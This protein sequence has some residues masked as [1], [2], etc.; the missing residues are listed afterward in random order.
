MGSTTR[1]RSIYG[2]EYTP[3]G[4]RL[5]AWWKKNGERRLQK[6]GS[7]SAQIRLY[8]NW[9][10]ASSFYRRDARFLKT[11]RAMHVCV[12][13]RQAAHCPGSLAAAPR[14]CDDQIEIDIAKEAY[15]QANAPAK[16]KRQSPL[17][18]RPAQ[19]ASQGEPRL[20]ASI[21]RDRASQGLPGRCALSFF[22][23]L[24]FS[25]FISSK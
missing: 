19:R 8:L 16:P 2:G 7:G 4:L 6:A 13:R 1:R 12:H 10:A 20:A 25:L 3:T 11:Y 24:F 14:H 15:R 5:F 23:F 17:G 21:R 22:L 18:C 9:P